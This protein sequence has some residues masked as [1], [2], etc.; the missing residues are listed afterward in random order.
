MA[1]E[2]PAKEP[3]EKKAEVTETEDGGVEVSVEE[4]KE[5]LDEQVE[6]KEEPEKKPVVEQQHPRPREDDVTRWRNKAYAQDRIISRHEQ[7]IEDL[8]RRLEETSTKPHETV[9]Q[10]LDEL[11]KLAQ[12]D[13][14]AAVR[15]IGEEVAMNVY[16]SQQKVIKERAD[17]DDT[18]RVQQENIAAVVARHPELNDDVSEKARIYQDILAKNPRW[19]T[20]PDGPLLAMYKMEEEL[21]KSSPKTVEQPKPK[22]MAM[23]SSKPVS[24]GKVV[25]T[26]EQ[27]EFCDSQGINYSDYAR[28]LHQNEGGVSL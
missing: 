19:T 23:P 12:K 10:D 20:N 24:T 1:L 4:Q 11:D 27:K 7:Q 16:Q 22:N 28:A 26:R 21:G 8:K 5:K 9:Q 15:K 18:R 17:V 13:W 2:K 14:K 6:V 3:E 25:L